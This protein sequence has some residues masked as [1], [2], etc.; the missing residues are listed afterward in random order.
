MDFDYDQFQTTDGRTVTIMPK[1]K[2]W[3]V[4]RGNFTRKLFSLNAYL[5]Y[6]TK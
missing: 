6:M 4:T 2:L 3:M 5:H 1:E